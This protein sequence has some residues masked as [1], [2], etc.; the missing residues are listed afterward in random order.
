VNLVGTFNVIRL[1]AQTMYENT[2]D[3]EGGQ[4]GVIVNSA[5]IAAFEGQRGQAAY[6]ASK[7]GIAGLTL[8]VAR[9]LAYIGIR[10]MAIA[11]GIFALL[12]CFFSS[13]Y[14]FVAKTNVEYMYVINSQITPCIFTGIFHS[15][16]SI[17]VLFLFLCYN[18]VVTFSYFDSISHILCIFVIF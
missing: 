10:V 17:F 12:Q 7:G 14:C 8:P 2:P 13:N 15:E 11:P 5:S 16:S 3:V 1:A 9:D 18:I 4:R 6:A